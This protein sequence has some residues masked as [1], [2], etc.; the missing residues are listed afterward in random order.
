MYLQVSVIELVISQKIVQ[1]Y[2]S[3][4]IYN[5][6]TLGLGRI[7]HRKFAFFN[8]IQGKIFA[9]KLTID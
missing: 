8:K 6:P 3:E 7:L 9:G 1:Y 5:S 4:T 2:S